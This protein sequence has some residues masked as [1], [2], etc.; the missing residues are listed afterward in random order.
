M[1]ELQSFD[2]LAEPRQLWVVG[3]TQN[4]TDWLTRLFMDALDVE[5]QPTIGCMHWTLERPPEGKVCF[6][7]R[8]PRDTI[9]SMM[10]HLQLPNIDAVFYPTDQPALLPTLAD[11]FQAWLMK[12]EPEAVTRYERLLSDTKHELL[13]LLDL[14]RINYDPERIDGVI[15][16]QIIPHDAGSWRKILNREQG[17]KI[18]YWLGDWMFRMGYEME[19]DWWT[20]LPKTTASDAENTQITE[21]T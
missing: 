12:L 14:L 5:D 18:D 19:S 10:H 15:E 3:F 16:R 9:A 13:S 8:D 21:P 17:S 20:G 1:A 7:Y 2:S 4:G 6:I 11:Y